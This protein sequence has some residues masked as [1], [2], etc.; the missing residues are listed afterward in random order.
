MAVHAFA[1]C[2]E[3]QLAWVSLMA[4]G[5]GQGSERGLGAAAPGGG[6]A[7]GAADRVA[8]GAIL[9]DAGA[10]SPGLQAGLGERPERGMDVVIGTGQA[11]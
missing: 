11:A 10:S 2:V 1:F 8:S 5:T 7:S 9:S 4:P 3:V 6:V